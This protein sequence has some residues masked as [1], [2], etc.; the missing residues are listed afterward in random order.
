VVHGRQRPEHHPQEAHELNPADP[1]RPGRLCGIA[2][3]RLP[4]PSWPDAESRADAFYGDALGLRRVP[5]PEPE[6]IPGCWYEGLGVALHLAVEDPFMPAH[7]AHPVL[8]VDDLDALKVRVT[9]GGGVLRLLCEEL[10]EARGR[11]LPDQPPEG[12]SRRGRTDDPFGNRLELVEATGPTPAMFEAL[13]DRSMYPISMIDAAGVFRWAG[14]SHEQFF[15]HRPD[16][17]VGQRFDTYVAP[18]ALGAAL[19]A[20]A[21]LSE[22]S[23]PT[24]W[25][26]VAFPTDLRHADGSLVACEVAAL[27]T[28]RSGL[29]WHAIVIRQAGYERAVD[30]TLEAMSEGAS[31]GVLL[32]LVVTAVQEMMPHAGV[33]VGD[34]WTGDRFEVSAG[35]AAHLLVAHHD[36]PWTRALLSGEDQYLPDRSGLPGPVAALARAHGYEACWVQPVG[37]DVDQAPTAAIVVWRPIDGAPTTYMEDN[38]RRAGQLLR[39][40]LQWDRSRRTLEFAASH[41]PLTGLANRQ[42]FRERL[43]TVAAA[44]EGQAA[45]LYLD[46]DHFKPVNDQIGHQTGDRALSVVAQRLVGALR[47]GDLVARIGGDEFAVLCERLTS[48][49]DVERVARRLLAAVRQP[50]GGLAPEEIRLDGSIGVADVRPGEMVD[51]VLAR[52]DEAMRA[53]KQ[54]GR[55]RWVRQRG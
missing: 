16:D 50:I 47:P 18:G 15:G 4:M 40:T 30:R 29:P 36:A 14:S 37:V 20:F 35:N 44:G 39:L 8:L 34:R 27:P 7:G 22:V 12:L 49:D 23:E 55:G 24:P 45:V 5:A 17:M 33:A 52:A 46:L 38:L 9:T 10:T 13:A 41:D 21:N 3:V 32:S 26:G 53:A 25:G 42:T 48:P 19:H 11:E 6:A 31:L 43:T 2:H 54:H 1:P 51:A 28:H